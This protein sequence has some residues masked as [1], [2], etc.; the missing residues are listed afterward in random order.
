MSVLD[1]EDL[2]YQKINSESEKI[3][4]YASENNLKLSELTFN[5]IEKEQKVLCESLWKCVFVDFR[6]K[7]FPCF[8]TVDD[9]LAFGDLSKNSFDEI[10]NNPVFSSHRKSRLP[11]CDKCGRTLPNE[12][13][14]V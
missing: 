13:P 6:G 4:K 7:V 14:K 3:R 8:M 1:L 11:P 10:W 5:D 2:D 12:K 9:S